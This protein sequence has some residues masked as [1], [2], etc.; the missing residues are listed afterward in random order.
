MELASARRVFCSSVSLLL[1]F[2]ACED[3]SGCPPKPAGPESSEVAAVTPQTIVILPV[4]SESPVRTESLPPPVAD[5]GSGVYMWEY[6]LS[7][8]GYA[9]V[10]AMPAPR[11]DRQ[12]VVIGKMIHWSTKD[13]PTSENHWDEQRWTRLEKEIGAQ[14]RQ[15]Q[16]PHLVDVT[17]VLTTQLGQPLSSLLANLGFDDQALQGDS[18][19]FLIWLRPHGR[20]T[21]RVDGNGLVEGLDVV[22]W[23]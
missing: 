5:H 9:I 13:L 4:G 22:W 14:L 11:S 2:S 21:V 1:V 10:A 15:V 19:V 17:S 8:A 18:E 6:A 7:P 16:T 3:R 23:D 20:A 12:V